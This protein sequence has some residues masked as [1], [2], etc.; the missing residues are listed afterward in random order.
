[1][2]EETGF[3]NHHVSTFIG[4]IPPNQRTGMHRHANEAAV[5]ILSGKGYSIIGEEK[6][7]W[8]EGDTLLVPTF[9]WH[10]HFNPNNRPVRFLAAIPG[11]W[12]KSMGF[13]R[14]EQRSE[15]SD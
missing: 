13:H 10:Q 9:E 12:F 2:A 7:E 6:I 15:R 14:I 3:A 1:M 5:Y 8:E 11:P 4:E